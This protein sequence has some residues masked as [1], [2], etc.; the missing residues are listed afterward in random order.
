MFEVSSAGDGSTPAS[1]ATSA[2]KSRVAA[3]PIGTVRIVCWP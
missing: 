1:A 2:M 3:W